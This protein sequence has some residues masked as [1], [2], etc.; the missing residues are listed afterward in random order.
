MYDELQ[1][2]EELLL[3][4]GNAYVVSRPHADDFDS[5][6]SDVYFQ[7][8]DMYPRENSYVR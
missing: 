6:A 3:F 4:V 2:M 1:Y 7:Y 5:I 8:S